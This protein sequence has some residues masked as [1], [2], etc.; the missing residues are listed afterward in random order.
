MSKEA[1]KTAVPKLRFPEFREAGEWEETQL[2]EVSRIVAGQSPA[3]TCYNDKGNGIP[4]YQGKT[5]FGDIYLEK[6]TKWTTQVTKLAGQ[7]DILM[8]VRAP[9][10]ALN[11]AT[12]EICIGRGLAAIQPFDSRWFLYYFLNSIQKSIIGNGG[13][14]F[15]SINKEQ[16]EAIKVQIPST[17]EQQKIAATLFSLD[18]LITA[19]NA[20]LE[21][22]KTHK[23]GLMQRLFPTE[24]ETVPKLRFPEFRDAGEWDIKLLGEVAKN[25][26]SKR[27]PITESERISGNVPYY[28]ASGIIDYVQDYLFDEDLLCISEDGANLMA[29][30][31]P[32]AFSITGKTWVN[33]HAH[34]IRFKKRFTQVLVENYLNAISLEGFLTGMAQPKLNR[35][36]LDIISVPLPKDEKEQQRIANTLSSL[37]DLIT[38]QSQKIEA[39]KLHKKGLMQ[40][41]FPAASKEDA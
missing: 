38:A 20:K 8:S 28:G 29:R 40:V 22:L 21:A 26:D 7:G 36:K 3:G 13:S 24:G 15:D 30:T 14:I 31:Y 19:Q 17:D 34:V 5:D 1:K 23:R 41:L 6:P 11:I 2:S 10:G 25:L 33:N 18:D 37:D 4:F 16:I 39:L 35:A 12:H 27:V 9:V 32:I